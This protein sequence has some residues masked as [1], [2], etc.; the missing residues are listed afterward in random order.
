MHAP[1]NSPDVCTAAGHMLL[2]EFLAYDFERLPT[3]NANEEV[4]TSTSKRGALTVAEL[5][6]NTQLV[7]ITLEG[8]G[9]VAEALGTAFES[10]LM[11]TM[12]VMHMRCIPS[13]QQ[14]TLCVCYA[15]LWLA[16]TPIRRVCSPALAPL[17][18][19]K[20]TPVPTPES[21]QSLSVSTQLPHACGTWITDGRGVA[22]KPRF[23]A[24][25]LSRLQQPRPAGKCTHGDVDQ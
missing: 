3:H 5:T 16:E 22:C 12:Y 13:C 10:S 20:I 2:D 21:T 25:H 19:P 18:H 23:H 7:C 11:S 1:V 8:I 9:H 4:S 6:H 24:P 14:C 17:S 15:C